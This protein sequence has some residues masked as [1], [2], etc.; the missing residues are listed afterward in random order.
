MIIMMMDMDT[1]NDQCPWVLKIVC[2]SLQV[3]LAIKDGLMSRG[4]FNETV[5]SSK[6]NPHDSSNYS[7][8][9]G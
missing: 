8:R 2:V 1:Q 9:W 7:K 6:L 3:E 5:F 4:T